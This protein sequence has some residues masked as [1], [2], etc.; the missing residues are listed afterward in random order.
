MS[1]A[2]TSRRLT[3][4]YPRAWRARYGAELEALI[5][6]TAGGRSVPW[7][8]RIDV[9]LA[10]A[11]EHVRELRSGGS[12]RPAQERARSGMIA[13]L[14]AWML[15]VCAGVV[16]QKLSEHWQD[17]VPASGRA[18]PSV[19]FDGLVAGAATGFALLFAG[20]VVLVPSV[21]A[22]VRSGGFSEIR[23]P[24][25]R[26]VAATLIATAAGI[27]V[28]IWAH[29]LTAGER[30]GHDAAY[31]AGVIALGVLASF[32]LAA[33]VATGAAVLR[34]LAL[35]AGAL[36]LEALAATGLAVAMGAMTASTLVWWRAVSAAAPGFLSGE[37]LV[38]SAAAMVTATTIG[39]IGAR[40]ALRASPG[41]PGDQ[42]AEAASR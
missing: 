29:H 14:W 33:W 9:A 34:R 10:A 1:G 12:G 11:H 4:L 17:S 28:V 5:L 8:I 26:S 21:L 31:G 19:A 15:F 37:A 18:V 39:A 22:F 35:P 3:R 38:V 30:N 6:E 25:A 7:R 32:C 16:V 40:R 20:A 42:S 23:S 2:R 13:V 36:R 27:C 41:G 24:L